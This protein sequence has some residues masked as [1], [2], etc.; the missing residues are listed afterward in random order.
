MLASRHVPRRGRLQSRHRSLLEPCE[1]DGA[2]CSDGSA[3]T[4]SDTC[5][6]GACVGGS[7]VVCGASDQCH[8]IGACNPANGTCSNPAKTNGASCNDGNACTQSDSCQAGA[9]TGTNPIVCAALDQCHDVGVCNPSNGVCSTPAKTDGAG[10]NDGNACTKTDTCL[11][12]RCTGGNPVVMRRA[13]PVSRSGYVRSFQRSLL[14]SREDQ[15]IGLQRWQ[16]LHAVR[17]VPSGRVYRQQPSHVCRARSVPRCWCLRYRQRQLLESGQSE[18]HAVQRW[19]CVHAVRYVPVGDVHGASP[20]VCAASDQCHVAGTCNPANGVCSDPAKADGSTCVDGNAC[21]QTDTCQA[22]SCVGDNPVTCFAQDQC[23]D[24]GT[25]NPSNGACSNPSKTDGALCTDGNACTQVDACQAG[26]CIGTTPVVCAALDQCHVAG[27]CD[28][29]N[30]IC[31]NPAQQDGTA[32]DD[33]TACTRSD[34]CQT[35]Q[36][37]GANPVV[38]AAKDQCHDVGVCDAATGVCSDPAKTDGATCNDGDACTKTD[39][40]VAGACSGANPVTCEALDQC[41]DPGTCDHASGNCSN[42]A[43]AD[44]VTC[45][46]KDAC[47]RKDSCQT[48]SCQGTDPVVCTASDECHAEGTCNPATGTCS[49]P[50]K[51]DGAACSVGSCSAGLC[52]AVKDAG[53]DGTVS[54]E[55]GGFGDS[56]SGSD[57]ASSGLDGASSARG[58]GSTDG[59]NLFDGFAGASGDLLTLQPESSSGC[60]CRLPSRRASPGAYGGLL[61]A[62]LALAR[63]R[64]SAS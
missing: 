16:R 2:S 28:P 17:H 14:E 47:T 6:A 23:H 25:C 9:C 58:D 32:C 54:T 11:A 50:K 8:D 35:G 1:M 30:G 64:R 56:G 5:K 31:T 59:G 61:L 19:Q 41:H 46:D 4:Q 42:P 3:C 7:P 29:Q 21:T 10:C 22:G 36:C 43:K 26:T 63:R 53:S 49:N 52:S 37:V 62:F 33:N 45:D 55:G 13:R 34:T 12:G 57:A 38:C 44:G 20:V 27:L 24:P 18:Q 51:P 15:R 60:G 39:T 40:C 48:G